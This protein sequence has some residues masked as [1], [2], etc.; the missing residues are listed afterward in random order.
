[1]ADKDIQL[2]ETRFGP[3]TDIEIEQWVNEQIEWLTDAHKQLHQNELP[4][5]RKLYDG[6]PASETKS[7]PWPNASNVVVQVIGET[8]DTTVAWVLGVHYATHPL[9]V[10]QNY[11]KAPDGQEEEFEKQR[12][13]MEDFMDLM[14]YEPTEL[15]LFRKEGIWYTDACKLGTAF[16]K[17][18]YE[19][20]VEAVVVGYS[21][22]RKKRI[23]FDDE[24]LFSGPQFDNLRHEDIL[25]YPDAATLAKSGF[26][27]QIRTLR[28]TQLE[29]RAILGLYNRE[30]VEK[31]IGSPDRG[32]PKNEKQQELQDQGIQV[33]HGGSSTAEWDIHECYFPWWH[34]GHKFRLIL[35][36]H[37]QTRTVLRSVFNF[38]P[39]NE[40]PIIR[41]RLGYRNGGMYGRGFAKI[42]EWYQEEISTIHNQRNDNATAANTR[43]LRVSPRARNLDSNLEIYPFSLLVGEKDEIEAIPIADV[44]Q[45]SFQNEEMALRHVQSRAGVAPSIAGSGQGGMKQRP[46]VYSSMGTLAA[47]QEGT[48]R[49]NLEVT[50]FRHAHVTLGS[51][52]ARMYA[53]FGPG[54]K[55]EIFGLDANRL[56]QAL[57]AVKTNHL[58]IPIRAATASLNKEV[59][60]QS[61]ML[62]VGMMQRHYT[63]MGQL[64][65][66]INNPVI[67]PMVQDYLI[68]VIQSS[69]RTM[70]RILK[71]FG[72]DQPDQFIPEPKIQSPQASG[73]N[74][75]GQPVQN[76][77]SPAPGGGAGLLPQ[78][79]GGGAAGGSIPVEAPGTGRLNV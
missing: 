4:K 9:W 39:Q 75:S 76:A 41:A 69:N 24:T 48:T 59:E 34:N 64:M 47:M 45:S 44:Y 51:L 32:G 19:H 27:A 70:K 29:E 36:Y 18:S 13:V 46:N 65:Q 12:A 7:F 72:Y 5:M 57:E 58:K 79:G 22:S 55:A 10:F 33:T 3:D 61:G 31:I 15:D 6:V 20:K 52:L 77:P 56:R 73:A 23:E 71:D 11:R 16:G 43:M 60:K 28:K 68:K 66:A 67:P 62:M 1:M 42:L 63:S 50:D 53:K 78:P 37:K 38:L 30:M 14:G 74:G 25:T 35:S 17:V 8:V 54:A 2:V 26:N 21:S 49:T 40:L